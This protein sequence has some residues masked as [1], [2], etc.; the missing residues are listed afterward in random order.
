MRLFL[1][2]LGFL[3]VLITCIV[4]VCIKPLDRTEIQNTKHYQAWKKQLATL[5]FENTRG[6]LQVGW[7]KENFT[8]AKPIP[9]A[10]YGV[11]K[12]KVY[13]NVHDSVYVRSVCIRQGNVDRFLV[14]A[15]LLIIPPVVYE[16]LQTAL[17]LKNI[18]INNIYFSATH[19]HN[20]LGAWGKRLGQVFAG[21]YDPAVEDF[22]V[23][24]FEKAILN[25]K[26]DL[27]NAS[28]A[29]GETLDSTDIR[30]R[31]N[32]AHPK[33]DPE[34]R[35]LLIERADGSSAHIMSYAAHS[36]VLNSSTVELSRDYPGVLVDSLEASHATFAM[37]MAGAVASMGPIEKGVD[38]FDEVN[39]Q[40]LGVF[41]K[42]KAIRFESLEEV[43]SLHKVS[44]PLPEPALKISQNFVLRPFVFKFLFGEYPTHVSVLKIGKTLLLG[45]PC[46]FSGEL[47]LGLDA[48]AKQNGL[49]L[50]I[51][52]FNGA[53][54]GYV[55][56]DAHFDL[57]LY[58]T[59]TMAWYGY[60]NGKYFSEIVKGLI[61]KSI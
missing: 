3:L 29:Y 47:M 53:Y 42:S 6:P 22:L 21:P 11:R 37:F 31:L 17:A 14:S 24:K 12:G 52:S 20:S 58:E 60:Q 45:M 57:D 18:P 54:I 1:K 39:N 48:F 44:I 33:I 38:D 7:A 36:T 26:V 10:G 56:D 34:I 30:N 50:V 40:A 59:R 43:L 8:P 9:L 32:L 61:L 55:T 49:N 13:Q 28:F 5:R 2:I 35:S 51:N 23:Q 4:L 41:K 25:S 16:K 19:S 46:D 15:D 27:K